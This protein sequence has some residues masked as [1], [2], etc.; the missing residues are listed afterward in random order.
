MTGAAARDW[1]RIGGAGQP[2]GCRGRQLQRRRG[3]HR[4]CRG[5][6]AAGVAEIVVV[7]NGSSDGSLATLAAGDE[8]GAD[9]ADQ[10]EPRLRD[11]GEPGRRALR[12]A[13]RPRPQPPT[14][15]STRGPSTCWA[16]C[17]K[18][19]PA[20]WPSSGPWIPRTRGHAVPVGEIVPELHGGGRARPSWGCSGPATPGRGATAAPRH[21]TVRR[22]RGPSESDWVS[23]ACCLV[24]REGIVTV[25]GVRRGLL[26]VRRGDFDLCWRAL[27][28]RP[29]GVCSTSLP[30]WP[31]TTRELSA[32]YPPIP[33]A[34]RPPPLD[35]ALRTQ[36]VG[37]PARPRC[38]SSRWPAVSPWPVS[39]SPGPSSCS[40]A[41]GRHQPGLD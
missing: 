20:T 40:L 7:D 36:V 27:R 17:L 28:A 21:P 30:P 29:G 15:S 12:R 22:P 34:R 6:P 5:L 16:V 38:S 2:H 31:S 23:G 39:V 19:E 10:E 9:R 8:E 24:R 35:A 25:G 13:V 14:S 1:Q 32:A 3:A 37:R 4:L 26:H 11:G 33:H 18:A 41:A